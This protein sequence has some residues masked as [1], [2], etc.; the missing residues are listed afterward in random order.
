MESNDK[1]R[2]DFECLRIHYFTGKPVSKGVGR[3]KSYDYIESAWTDAGE[4]ELSKWKEQARQLISQYHEECLQEDLLEWEK[5][6]NY[7]N[8][9]E[10]KLELDS[11]DLHISRMFDNPLWVDY[12]PFNQKYRPTVLDEAHLI[13]VKTACCEEPGLTT[14]E[15][16]EAARGNE[17]SRTT[18]CPCCGR[19]SAFEIVDEPQHNIEMN[20]T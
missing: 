6:H 15:Q 8:S 11:L 3:G 17:G 20:F 2:Q 7:T 19:W 5:N 18:H 16:V 12:V 13:W 10:S 1:H 9:N 4:I 14:K